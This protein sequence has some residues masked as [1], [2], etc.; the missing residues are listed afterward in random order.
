MEESKVKKV[1]IN[2]YS[3]EIVLVDGEYYNQNKDYAFV[4]IDYSL[5]DENP[6]ILEVYKNKGF[7]KLYDRID[8]G[9]VDVSIENINRQKEYKYVDFFVLKRFLS[10]SDVTEFFY[11]KVTIQLCGKHITEFYPLT[12]IGT[13][14]DKNIITFVT[15]EG[16]SR[17]IFGK[18]GPE[19]DALFGPKYPTK[20]HFL[21]DCGRYPHEYRR[22]I[23]DI[24]KIFLTKSYHD[25]EV[26]GTNDEHLYNGKVEVLELDLR[27]PDMEIYEQ[28]RAIDNCIE[29][30]W[31]NE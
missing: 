29:V 16:N 28:M 22:P 15:Y 9:N 8:G 10:Q 13:C 20:N 2:N 17:G 31:T 19:A 26:L 21:S 24:E 1:M 18:Y 25:P 3:D 6:N 12:D 4:R 11:Y 7:T 14:I 23:T 27:N 30:E 5:I